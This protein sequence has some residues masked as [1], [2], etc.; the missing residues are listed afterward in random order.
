MSRPSAVDRH[1]V[2]NAT[3]ALD[4]VFDHFWKWKEYERVSLL[5]AAAEEQAAREDVDE[6]TL[7]RRQL[8]IRREAQRLIFNKQHS[9]QLVP[10]DIASHIRLASN[11]RLLVAV[12]MGVPLTEIV[13]GMDCLPTWAGM[14]WDAVPPSIHHLV[15]GLLVNKNWSVLID[16]DTIDNIRVRG[17]KRI[18]RAVRLGY[19]TEHIRIAPDLQATWPG[20]ARAYRFLILPPDVSDIFDRGP[21]GRLRPEEEPDYRHALLQETVACKIRERVQQDRLAR[22][23][24]PS[25]NSHPFDPPAIRFVDPHSDSDSHKGSNS[26]SDWDSRS[27]FNMEWDTN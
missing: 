4:D 6:S 18:T 19:R 26:D 25:D 3:L 14:R 12:E 16:P 1:M 5:V 8:F 2:R 7:S 15:Q 20:D 13:I 10:A 24:S 17:N 9:N 23:M 21:G 27:H 11:Q 22:N